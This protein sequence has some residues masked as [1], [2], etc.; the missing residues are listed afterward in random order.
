MQSG[1]G[2]LF[3]AYYPLSIV[4]ASHDRRNAAFCRK[5]AQCVESVGRIWQKITAACEQ[6]W[7]PR[8]NV[9][10]TQLIAEKALV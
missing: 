3:L 1:K 6:D 9:A 5:E 8:Y 2:L 10:P 7:E 4:T